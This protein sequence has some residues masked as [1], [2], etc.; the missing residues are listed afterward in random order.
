MWRFVSL[1][2]AGTAFASLVFAPGGGAPASRAATARPWLVYQ[3]T[4][5]LRSNY[6]CDE[7][8]HQLDYLHTWPGRALATAG[9]TANDP[10]WSP[11]GRRIAFSSGGT[12]CTNGDGIGQDTAQIWV[13]DAGGSSVHRV[14]RGDPQ[15]AGP[16]D[17]SPSWSPDSRRLAFAR[18]DIYRGTRGIYTVGSDGRGLTRLVARSAISLDWSPDGRSIAFVPG[19]WATFGYSAANR[20]EI[21][22]LRSHRI[23]RI[24]VADPY[25][26]AWSPNGR[27]IAATTGSHA[28]AILT[29]TTASARR[30]PV[31]GAG[32]SWLNGVTWSPDGR[33]LAYS[34]GTTI[35]VVRLDGGTPTR[36]TKGL[37]PDWR[38]RGGGNETRG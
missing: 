11:D 3:T 4:A 25:D 13:I 19:E 1:A 6:G 22:D 33:H 16:L 36:V 7:V 9:S 31:R 30:I 32:R 23:R 20:I 14:T 29:V 8:P 26:L 37:A 18:T 38:P 27:T 10:A 24:A 28:I 12:V 21:L 5:A 34:D 15:L 35:Y 17:R 2:L